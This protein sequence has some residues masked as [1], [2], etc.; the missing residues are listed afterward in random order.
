M[1][2][3]ATCTALVNVWL[4]AATVVSDEEYLA[5]V[6]VYLW[7][8]LEQQ[9]RWEDMLSFV[10][11]CKRLNLDEKTTLLRS[12]KSKKVDHEMSNQ[13]KHDTHSDGDKADDGLQCDLPVV[14]K[15]NIYFLRESVYFIASLMHE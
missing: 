8:V 10:E 2:D 4:R 1:Q 11:S 9:R 7:D 12:V 13:L 5:V 6:K 14:N 3:W 15:S